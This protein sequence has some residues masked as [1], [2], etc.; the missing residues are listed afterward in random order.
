M[1]KVP[2]TAGGF[3]ALEVEL[4]QRLSERCHAHYPDPRIIALGLED[5]GLLLAAK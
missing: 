5:Q 2:M 1:D 4:K 3:A